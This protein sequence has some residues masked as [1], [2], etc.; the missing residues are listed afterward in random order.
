MQRILIPNA[1]VRI[2]PNLDTKTAPAALGICDTSGKMTFATPSALF[3]RPPLLDLRLLSGNGGC[4]A[5]FGEK[6]TPAK[7]HNIRCAFFMSVVESS[8]NKPLSD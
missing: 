4:P 5:W 3:G 2:L 7:F 6:R 8:V 1:E